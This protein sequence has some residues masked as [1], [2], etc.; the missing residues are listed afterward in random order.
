MRFLRNDK[1]VDKVVANCGEFQFQK[2]IYVT[3]NLLRLFALLE[4]Q[5]S[6]NLKTLQLKKGN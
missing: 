2:S 5:I 4:L 1:F 3:T 6:T